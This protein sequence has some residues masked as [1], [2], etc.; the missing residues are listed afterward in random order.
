MNMSL[1]VPRCPWTSARRAVGRA[2]LVAAHISTPAVGVTSSQPQGHAE[3]A[4][5]AQGGGDGPQA[6]QGAWHARCGAAGRPRRAVAVRRA[7]DL[8]GKLHH[9]RIMHVRMTC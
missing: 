3:P 9:G 2:K 7:R 5:A 4:G 1:R 8:G 6:Q